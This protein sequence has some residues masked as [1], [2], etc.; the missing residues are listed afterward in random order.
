MHV[1]RK[2]AV[3][4]NAVHGA[5]TGNVTVSHPIMAVPTVL[6]LVLVLFKREN[7][8]VINRGTHL[9]VKTRAAALWR[10]AV[11]VGLIGRVIVVRSVRL[12]AVAGPRAEAGGV[13]ISALGYG[14]RESYWGLPENETSPFWSVRKFLEFS[15]RQPAT[16]LVVGCDKPLHRVCTNASRSGFFPRSESQIEPICNSWPAS[17]SRSWRVFAFWSST[18]RLCAGSRARRWGRACG[19]ARARSLHAC[20]SWHARPVR[21][22]I[23]FY[24][25]LSSSWHRSRPPLSPPLPCPCCRPRSPWAR[26]C[27]VSLDGGMWHQC[28]TCASCLDLQM[29]RL[30]S[31]LHNDTNW[32]QNNATMTSISRKRMGYIKNLNLKKNNI[33][34]GFM[35]KEIKLAIFKRLE[36]FAL[37]YYLYNVAF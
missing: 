3:W 17:A 22:W 11:A 31:S 36:C 12:D 25:D 18:A 28:E 14:Y 30:A 27:W 4:G 35:T 32:Q 2:M 29:V 24:G 9:A 7:P 26:R 13:A 8:V 20:A 16:K 34:F 37:R 21:R 1:V 19:C 5:P 23:S 6:D 10:G 15:C 33:R